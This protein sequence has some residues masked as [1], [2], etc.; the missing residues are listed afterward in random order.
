MI[1]WEKISLT[2]CDFSRIF[3]LFAEINRNKYAKKINNRVFIMLSNSG[4]H[5]GFDNGQPGLFQW[6]R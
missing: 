2:K 5:S 1:G 3:I 4:Y 6:G